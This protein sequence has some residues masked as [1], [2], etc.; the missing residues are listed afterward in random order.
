MSACYSCTIGTVS[1]RA[2]GSHPVMKAS[3]AS[4]MVPVVLVAVVIV[5][6]AAVWAL[7][8]GLFVAWASGFGADSSIVD[9]DYLLEPL[10]EASGAR[11]ALGLAGAVIAVLGVVLGRRL[12]AAGRIGRSTV[13]VTVASAAVAAYA[14][15][16]YGVATQPTIGANI[17]AG[18]LLLGFV[19]FT[20]VMV[21]LVIAL[22]R[23]APSSGT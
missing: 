16:V 8:V 5:A 9:P 11:L 12:F 23:R 3:A 13:I 21:V 19:P 20:I 7:A 6:G 22:L 17:G 15:L 2:G 18:I 14:G 10:V 4:S 1:A